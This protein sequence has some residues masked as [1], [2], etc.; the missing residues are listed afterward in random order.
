MS[1]QNNKKTIGRIYLGVTS[2][3]AINVMVLVCANAI[4]MLLGNVS[5][6]TIDLSAIFFVLW[7]FTC[8]IPL[9][10]LIIV[11]IT[12]IV[13]KKFYALEFFIMLALCVFEVITFFFALI[14]ANYM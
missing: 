8:G 3:I 1:A 7:F 5:R 11:G 13:K 12:S 2:F 6:T 9:V 14:F 4:F 10:N